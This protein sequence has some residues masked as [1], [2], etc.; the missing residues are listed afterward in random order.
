[1]THS[2]QGSLFSRNIK[3]WFILFYADQRLTQTFFFSP[4]NITNFNSKNITQWIRT[5]LNFVYIHLWRRKQHIYVSLI[6]KNKRPKFYNP[7]ILFI[8]L[9]VWTPITPW[10][11]NAWFLTTQ[12]NYICPHNY[13]F[14]GW[15]RPRIQLNLST[16][17]LSLA[18]FSSFSWSFFFTS[19]RKL[20][21]LLEYICSIATFSWQES[22]P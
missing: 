14:S 8:C 4:R 19:F 11:H 7:E 6:E 18:S 5:W 9:F 13:A 2:V 16:E 10:I 15:S 1:M 20:I 21:Q 17:S 22:C 12:A 3:V